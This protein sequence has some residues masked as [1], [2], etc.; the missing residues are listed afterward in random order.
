MNKGDV[1]KI[2]C[3]FHNLNISVIFFLKIPNNL[4]FGPETPGLQGS[5][6]EIWGLLTLAFL[7]IKSSAYST[8]GI[9]L[10]RLRFGSE[11]VQRLRQD[12]I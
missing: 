6:Q 9:C 4:H 5:I 1:F 8:Q 7:S 3:R 12:N 10:Q 11:A 2:L